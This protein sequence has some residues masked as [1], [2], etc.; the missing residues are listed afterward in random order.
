MTLTGGPG[1]PCGPVSPGAP[2]CPCWMLERKC[3]LLYNIGH[4][5]LEFQVLLAGHW[6]LCHLLLPE[7]LGVHI[8]RMCVRLHYNTDRWSRGS[9]KT[10]FSSNTIISLGS[11]QTREANM[12]R[13]T[14]ISLVSLWPHTAMGTY[15]SRRSLHQVG[16]NNPS[17]ANHRNALYTG[18][19]ATP[20]GPCT[21]ATP[22]EPYTQCEETIHVPQWMVHVLCSSQLVLS[23]QFLPSPLVH[24]GVPI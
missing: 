12:S 11:W 24:Q 8:T 19:P 23:L 9:C 15:W 7:E 4:L 21:P 10:N 22:G 18:S 1:G 6:L 3:S 14:Y 13:G 20:V 5:L 16:H 2:I 17:T